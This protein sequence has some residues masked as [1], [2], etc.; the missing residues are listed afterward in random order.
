MYV[1][2]SPQKEPSYV[3]KYKR[4]TS[5]EPHADIRPTYNGVRPGSPMG[6]LTTLLLYPSAMQPSARY[7]PT[8]GL[9]VRLHSFL[10]L[11]LD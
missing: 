6:S 9:K 2:R 4:P 7:L 3:R 8:G 10:T 1:Y 5:T 11:A